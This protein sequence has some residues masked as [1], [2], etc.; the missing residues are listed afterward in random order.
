MQNHACLFQEVM[1]HSGS[2]RPFVVHQ[3]YFYSLINLGKGA[4][5]KSLPKHHP[6]WQKFFILTTVND[7]SYIKTS[8]LGY[9]EFGFSYYLLI[10][11]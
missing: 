2:A 6:P 10:I 3:K 1:L 5:C 11:L 7:L 8:F 4:V 9:V